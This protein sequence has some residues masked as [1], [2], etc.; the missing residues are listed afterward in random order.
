MGAAR[1]VEV[2]IR[3]NARAEIIDV[4][5][6][7]LVVALIDGLGCKLHLQTQLL[8]MENVGYFVSTAPTH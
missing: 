4:W 8:N 6:H 7:V 5:S 2:S 3:A 1:Q